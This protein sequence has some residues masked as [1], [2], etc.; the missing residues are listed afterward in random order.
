M[1]FV[2]INSHLRRWEILH[3]LYSL[4]F[5]GA[6]LVALKQDGSNETKMEVSK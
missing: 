3:F 2:R 5:G 4:T 6:T 1:G